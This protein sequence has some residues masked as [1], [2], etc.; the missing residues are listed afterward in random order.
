M[1]DYGKPIEYNLHWKSTLDFFKEDV[2]DVEDVED[3]F[4][5]TIMY[6]AAVERMF[7][8]SFFLRLESFSSS[9]LFSSLFLFFPDTISF[10]CFFC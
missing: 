2:E 7:N 9:I 5:F 10:S 6:D 8:P 4:F 3:L 1:P